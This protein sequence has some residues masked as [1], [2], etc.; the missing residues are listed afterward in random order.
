MPLPQLRLAVFVLLL[1]SA[2]GETGTEA[3]DARE[4][5]GPLACAAAVTL[6]WD[7]Q[8]D[9]A[10]V[11][12]PDDLWVVDDPTTATG[13]R[14]QLEANAPWF[15]DAPPLFRDVWSDVSTLDGW[16]TSAGI[17]LRFS[18]VVE[19]PNF[20]SGPVSAEPSSPIQLIAMHEDGPVRVPFEARFTDGGA[21]AIL[22]PMVPLAPATRHGVLLSAA[23]LT[24]SGACV[25]RSPA[26]LALLSGDE[27]DGAPP[28]LGPRVAELLR[29]AANDPKDVSAAFVF[30]TQSLFDKSLAVAED[31]RGRTYDWS[32]PPECALEDGMR[33][34]EGRFKAHNY[35][36][37]AGL[38]ADGSPQETY[39]LSVTI[40]LPAE[41]DGPFPFAMF[42]HGLRDSRHEADV[43]ASVLTTRGFAVVAMDAIAHGDHPDVPPSGSPHLDLTW[44]FGVDLVDR[45]L[46]ARRLRDNFRQTTFDRLQLLRVLRDAPD[47]DGDGDAEL[48]VG[49]GKAAYVAESF[50][51]IMGGALVALSD[52]FGA[53]V[54][55]IGGARVLN[56]VTEAP[57][58][59]AIFGFL[60]P[61]GAT[62]ADMDRLFALAQAVVEPGDPVNWGPWM[63]QRRFLGEP[64]NVAGI[65]I[66]GDETI[67][68]WTSATLFRALGLPHVPPL[69]EPFPLIPSTAA[70]PVADNL[71]VAGGLTRTG[72]FVQID[73]MTPLGDE[74]P[75]PT[76]HD[77]V[78]A[79]REASEF[80]GH[81][82]DTW[83]SGGA[84]IIDPIEV[85]GTPDL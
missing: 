51:S 6:D 27:V 47:F 33:R 84:E 83:Q 71:Q 36:D 31:I 22:W 68:S 24:P 18:G 78:N 59:D 65:I 1:A 67:P 64:P 17:V 41:G 19:G 4:P 60:T 58:F 66:V 43:T 20:P 32:R 11:A 8:S 45:R 34:C 14:V 23:P 35:R 44:F 5:L 28:T 61:D 48:D 9:Q 55:Q 77:F 57:R 50:G 49:A 63:L 39:E 73:R 81:F 2:C 38:L 26:M 21:T 75:V 15:Q 13:V 72:G 76:S 52:D 29:A 40:W 53:V 56:V 82:L 10:P 16:G 74:A 46:D 25:G 62:D 69:R 54:L 42:G 7:P 70:A 79:S 80:T 37:R 85:L 3:P 12:L 30:T